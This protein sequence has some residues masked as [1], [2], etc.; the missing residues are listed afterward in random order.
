MLSRVSKVVGFLMSG[1][2]EYLRLVKVAMKEPFS[3]QD[4]LKNN[5]KTCFFRQCRSQNFLFFSGPTMVDP[6]VTLSRTTNPQTKNL[7][8]TL[9]C[10]IVTN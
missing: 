2:Y 8:C 3:S 10:Q 4:L 9:H 5:Q 1:T 7:Y 6:K